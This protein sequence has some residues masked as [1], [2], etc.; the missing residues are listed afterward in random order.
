MIMDHCNVNG[1]LKC[2]KTTEITELHMESVMD[3]SAWI[4]YIIQI[5]KTIIY[6][7]NLYGN[8]LIWTS[9]YGLW[10]NWFE[11][12]VYFWNN[13]DSAQCKLDCLYPCTETEL[14]WLKYRKMHIGQQN[15][16]KKSIFLDDSMNIYIKQL[17]YTFQINPNKRNLNEFIQLYKYIGFGKTTSLLSLRSY[18]TIETV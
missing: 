15:N 8:K 1:L 12:N 14:R 4:L 10:S 17:F 11:L 7:L 5:W 16:V 13:I 2:L 18:H 6:H 9:T 3:F